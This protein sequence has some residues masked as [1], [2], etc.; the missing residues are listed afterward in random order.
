MAKYCVS[1]KASA[2][3]ATVVA[4]CCVAGAAARAEAVRGDG[5]AAA[6]AVVVDPSAPCQP[7][8]M[9]PSAVRE[10]VATEAK[11]QGLD[12]KLA[13]LIAQ[14]ESGL[15]QSLNSDKGARG[16]MQLIPATA[17]RYK[18]TDICDLEQNVRAGVSFIKDLS[19]KYRGNIFLILA[20][21]NAGEGRV[22]AARGVPPIA[23]TVR[24]VAAGANTY[25][26]LDAVTR[27]GGD[28][29]PATAPDAQNPSEGRAEAGGQ[30]WIAG[31]VLYVE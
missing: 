9:D 18:V 24:Y 30:K 31:S 23:E 27:Q 8:A 17:T 21:Y 26:D 19:E 25:F 6:T 13:V 11:R 7:L 15:G 14:Q 20:A 16:V 28:G 22:K 4:I 5:H 10:V 1:R 3:V 2:T 29:P 12:A